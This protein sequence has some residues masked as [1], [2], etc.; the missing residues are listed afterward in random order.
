MEGLN[1]SIF[2]ALIGITV[3]AV[4]ILFFLSM[5]PNQSAEK[6]PYDERNFIRRG[7]KLF[8]KN[9]SKK[10]KHVS[11]AHPVYPNR[12]LDSKPSGT[13]RQKIPYCRLCDTRPNHYGPP[14]YLDEEA[15][16]RPVSG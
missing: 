4:L 14:V 6:R 5:V 2:Y 13:R 7:R 1:Y 3:L 9:C 10:T 12:N 16:C 15:A 8:C 11:V